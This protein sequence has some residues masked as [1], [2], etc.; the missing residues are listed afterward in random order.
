MATCL[1]IVICEIP[2]VYILC[3]LF[4]QS[5]SNVACQS[6]FTT[7]WSFSLGERQRNGFLQKGKLVDI[8][9]VMSSAG[10]YWNAKGFDDCSLQ[11][12]YS[13]V[14]PCQMVYDVS[15][16]LGYNMCRDFTKWVSPRNLFIYVYNRDILK[17]KIEIQLDLINNYLIHT[18]EDLVYLT[19]SFTFTSVFKFSRYART[20]QFCEVTTHI[21]FIWSYLSAG[22]RW[23]AVSQCLI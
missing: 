10:K 23:R 19:T 18:Y 15:G 12:F 11:L 2:A 8:V 22:S 6:L 20:T 5:L 21:V 4:M 14:V 16:R 1:H 13:S 9:T 7:K 17:I 3:N